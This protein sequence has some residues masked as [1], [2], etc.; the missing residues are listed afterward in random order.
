[1]TDFKIQTHRYPMHSPAPHRAANKLSKALTSVADVAPRIC[2]STGAIHA[3]QLRL[4]AADGAT[5]RSN[6]QAHIVL[7]SRSF[8]QA[9]RKKVTFAL[10]HQLGVCVYI[11]FSLYHRIVVHWVSQNHREINANYRQR[12]AAPNII[13]GEI[14]YLNLISVLLR[15]YLMEFALIA[16][17]NLVF[18]LHMFFPQWCPMVC[19]WLWQIVPQLQ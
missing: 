6:Q 18:I 2:T 13:D 9:R 10:I 5:R 11:H 1:M 14:I 12:N 3:T 8:S 7:S 17:L 16:T 4:F 15:C 19:A